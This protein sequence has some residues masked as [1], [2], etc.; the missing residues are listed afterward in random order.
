MTT[1]DT[2]GET[3]TTGRSSREG[4]GRN[5]RRPDGRPKARGQFAFSSDLEAEGMLWGQL[6]RSPHASAAIRRIDLSGAL[7]IPGVVAV[8]TASDVPGRKTYGLD[9]PDQP[10]FASEVVRY[11]GE[12]LAA[13]AADHPVTARL[14]AEAIVVD[15]EVH[16]PLV[17]PEATLVAEPIHPLGNVLFRQVIRRGD[18]SAA[19]AVSVEGHYETGMQDQAFMGPESGLAVPAA[20]G[21]I[22]LYVATQWLHVDQDQIAACLDL[23][24]DMVRVHLAGVGGAFG[25][26]EDLSMQVQL[27]L[28]ALRT[29]R[30]VKIVYSREESFHG[31]VHRHPA[32][33]WYRHT[34]DTDGHLVSVQAR[35]VFDGGAYLSSSPAVTLNA[36]C[37]ANGPYNVPNAFVEATAVRTNNPPCGAMRGFGAVQVCF[38]HEAQMDKLAA[39]LEIDPIELRLRNAYATGDQLIIGQVLSGTA[40]VAEV[41]RACASAPLPPTTP[42]TLPE[43]AL[44]G[45]AGRTAERARVRRGVGFAVGFKNLMFSAGFDDYSTARC[46]L[47]DGRVTITSAAVEVGQGLVTLMQQIARDVLGV[48]E[49]TLGEAATVGIGSAGSTSASRQS[50]MT[51]GAVNRACQAVRERLLSSVSQRFEVA[52]AG[53]EL[54]SGRVVSADGSF[55]LTLS[56]AS[57]GETFEET[58]VFRHEGTAELD[59]NGQGKAHV[60]FAFAAHRAVVDVDLDLGLVKVVEVAT[61]QDVGRVLNPVQLLGQL[62]GGIS[63]GVGF[64]VMEEIVLDKG[65][66]RNPSFTDYIIPT[67]LDMPPVTVQALIEQAEPG[68]PLGAKGAGEPPS[69]SSTAAVVAAIR[70]ATGLDLPRAPVRPQDIALALAEPRP[71]GPSGTSATR[72]PAKEATP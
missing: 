14:A 42:D 49:V 63:Q 40:P 12:P 39:A 55:D 6:L 18:P 64:A 60:S 43:L 4:L 28:L 24:L 54:V 37:F 45:G 31:H 71:Q 2:R 69:I 57:A 41:I 66:V 19:G 15:Y 32:R 44:P 5:A 67:A 7:R 3:E 25:A 26:R 23:P 38:A 21:G 8:L 47:E 1:L 61:A 62:E 51:G 52:R 59:E 13:V 9:Y 56:E 17:D 27:C 11:A 36:A 65:I 20:D 29:G 10:V 68:S 35:I 58:A 22:D 46:R 33:M 30:P 53:L 72:P 50:W 34:A 70:N 48:D 16:E